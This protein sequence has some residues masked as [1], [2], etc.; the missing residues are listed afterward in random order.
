M[1]DLKIECRKML[2][3]AG[4]KKQEITKFLGAKYKRYAKTKPLRQT[5]TFATLLKIKASGG[6]IMKLFEFAETF[7]T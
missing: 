7:K 6:D 1:T 4:I 5:F 2:E 3:D